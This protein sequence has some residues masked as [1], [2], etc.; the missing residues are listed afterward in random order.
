MICYVHLLQKFGESNTC[1]IVLGAA[2]D[3]SH[4]N[5]LNGV[6]GRK[7]QWNEKLVLERKP[8]WCNISILLKPPQVNWKIVPRCFGL[9]ICILF[10]LNKDKKGDSIDHFHTDPRM[11]DLVKMIDWKSIKTNKIWLKTYILIWFS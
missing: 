4:C 7:V 5:F 3:D 9:V 8:R 6:I 11:D 10:L 2:I 1:T